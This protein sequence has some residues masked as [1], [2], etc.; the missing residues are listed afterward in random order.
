VTRDDIARCA[1][2]ALTSERFD[3]RTMELTGPEAIDL[4]ETADRLGAF[5]GRQVSYQEETVEEAYVSRASFNAPPWEVE[6][7]VS[8]YLAI[9]DGSMDGVTESVAELTDRRPESLEEFLSSNPESYQ[10]LLA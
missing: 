6:G 3:G 5:I 4:S 9:S 10:L 8:S 1:V 7:W 2:S